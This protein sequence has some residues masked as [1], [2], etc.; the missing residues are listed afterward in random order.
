MLVRA[1]PI[2]SLYELAKRTDHPWSFTDRR[3][4]MRYRKLL[5]RSQERGETSVAIASSGRLLD[6]SLKRI[7]DAIRHPGRLERRLRPVSETVARRFPG[8]IEPLA[9]DPRR[10]GVR[11]ALRSVSPSGFV[12]L[13]RGPIRAPVPRSL[14]SAAIEQR[15]IPRRADEVGEALFDQD[16]VQRHRPFRSDVLQRSPIFGGGNV[17]DPGFPVLTDTSAP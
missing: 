13:P 3:Q 12:L 11:H 2:A 9:S 8:I 16:G 17:D 1:R 7:G 14:L 5:H 15:A 4:R 10:Q 6:V